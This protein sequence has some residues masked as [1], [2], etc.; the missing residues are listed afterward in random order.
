MGSPLYDKDKVLLQR[1]QDRFIKR[2]ARRC[3]IPR[4]AIA[5]VLPTVQSLHMECDERVF[6]RL[7]NNNSLDAFF[8]VSR[9]FLRSGV[10]VNPLEIASRATVNNS[11]A[12]RLSHRIHS[13]AFNP[14]A[15]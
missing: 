5:G 6:R 13:K 9:N 7:M 4:A 2:V 11:F 10:N 8:D 12:W 1:V 3:A 14:F 15:S